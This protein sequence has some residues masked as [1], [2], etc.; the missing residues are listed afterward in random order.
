M[1]S[2]S[3]LAVEGLR[4]SGREVSRQR[5][6]TAIEEIRD[7][8]TGVVAPL[9]YSR[10]NTCTLRADKHTEKRPEKMASPRGVE[11]LLPP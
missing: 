2:A 5:L 1:V 7:F 6:R 3:C 11:P 4:R 8:R 10:S 9:S